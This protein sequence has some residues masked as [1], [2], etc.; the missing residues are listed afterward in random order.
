MSVCEN[1]MGLEFQ[2]CFTSYFHKKQALAWAAMLY[3]S[4][5]PVMIFEI[6][7]TIILLILVGGTIL[8]KR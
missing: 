6:L 5:V 1:I 2:F 4:R 7:G 8:Q 3:F